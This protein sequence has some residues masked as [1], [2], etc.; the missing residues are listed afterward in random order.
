MQV[1]IPFHTVYAVSSS[2]SSPRYNAVAKK[3]IFAEDTTQTYTHNEKII[4]ISSATGALDS[5][6]WSA[7]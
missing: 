4:N 2:F 7:E 6:T 3:N 1:S 5:V